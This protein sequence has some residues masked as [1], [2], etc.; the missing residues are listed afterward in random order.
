[1]EIEIRAWVQLKSDTNKVYRVHSVSDEF[2]EC[3]SSNG[4]RKALNIND[5]EPISGLE[6]LADLELIKIPPFSE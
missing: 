6:K 1:M 2:V 3:I 4:E 5:I